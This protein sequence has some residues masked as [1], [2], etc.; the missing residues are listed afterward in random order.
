MSVVRM[1]GNRLSV[2]D[3]NH[4]RAILAA[5]FQFP[6]CRPNERILHSPNPPCGSYSGSIMVVPQC[7]LL[8]P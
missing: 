5:L 6:I 4:K 8:D 3:C 1:Y 2:Y 7:H